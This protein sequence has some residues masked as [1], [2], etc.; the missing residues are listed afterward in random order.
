MANGD[1]EQRQWA[2]IVYVIP[3]SSGSAEGQL[4][5]WNHTD[6]RWEPSAA[7]TA[8]GQVAYWN[9]STKTWT[10]SGAPVSNGQLM[11]WNGSAWIIPPAP[12]YNGQLL[13]WTGSSW[14]TT[15]MTGVGAGDLLQWSG[16]A[17]LPVRP[18]TVT[19]VTDY[20][21]DLSSHY[22]QKKTRN[23]VVLSAAAESGWTNVTG[24]DAVPES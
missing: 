14:W 3:P 22:L 5:E 10:M 6:K 24:G 16:T 7:P 21:Y 12:S 17:W 9:A 4:C 18:V 1:I 23:L 11:S 8:N 19:V 2:D 15:S 13:V 20:Q